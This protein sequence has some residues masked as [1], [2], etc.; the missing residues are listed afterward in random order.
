MS[1]ATLEPRFA[2]TL[3]QDAYRLKDDITRRIVL[4]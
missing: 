3:A 4:S 1:A 2:A